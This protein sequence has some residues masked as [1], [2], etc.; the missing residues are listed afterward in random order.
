MQSIPVF[1]P[2]WA[3]WCDHAAQPTLITQQCGGT[4]TG[5]D[6]KDLARFIAPAWRRRLD[7]FGRASAEV[8]GRILA[9]L[10]QEQ[11][12]QTRVIFASRH[13]NIER[14]LK[15]LGQ[16]AREEIPSPADFSMSVH[17]ALVGVASINWAIT[18]SHS[19][20]S[21]GND[22]LVAALTEAL[23]QLADDPQSPVALV[24]IDLTL[25]GVYA[26]NDPAG[27][28]GTA[29]AMLIQSPD[30][31][32][33]GIDSPGNTTRFSFE[34]LAVSPAEAASRP[35]TF[36][37]THAWMMADFLKG[38]APK[39]TPSSCLLAGRSFAWHVGRNE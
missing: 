25:P 4:A 3:L 14:T 12:R 17:N 31:P 33:N 6:H 29:F 30:A 19:A 32:P 15:L 10:S 18:Q 16:I 5:I 8:L 22:S 28:T 37:L 26:Q 21:A 36:A 34:P 27:M 9:D 7:L 1:I 2:K 39:N 20:I 11:I 13:G 23:S 38:S 35:E 24:Y